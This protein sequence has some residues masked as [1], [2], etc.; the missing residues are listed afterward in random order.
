[1]KKIF[2]ITGAC[3][4]DRH[5]MVEL[6]PRLEK[7]KRMIDAGDYMTL[8]RPRQ[9]G[10]TTT[11]R[12]LAVYLETDYLVISLDFQRIS[13]A[14]F[15]H[16]AAFVH[17]LA[18][19]FGRRVRR[20]QEVPDTVKEELAD[21]ADRT[22]TGVRLA[23]FFDCLSGWCGQTE[24]PI[25]LLIDE[26]DTASDHQVFL[27]FLAQLRAAY[28]DRDEMPAF[29]SVIL[30]GLYDIKNLKLRIRPDSERK[31]NSPWNIAAKLPVD[32]SFSKGQIAAMLEEYESDRQ[33]GMDV[34]S[35]ADEIRQVLYQGI[36]I[37]YSPA[38]ESVNLGRMFGF[39]RDENGWVVIANRMFEMYLLHLFI[40]EES[41]K[42]AIYKCGERDR[43]QFVKNGRLNMR[44]VLEKFVIH[45]TDIY[46]G[47]EE[48][49]LEENGR[50]FFLLYLKP[51]INGTGNYYLEAQTRDARRTDVIVDYS[52]EQFI[53]ELKIWHGNEYHERGENQ[54]IEYLDD[55][56][57]DTGYL[58][59]FNFNK[60]KEIGVKELRVRG[61]RI[62]EAVV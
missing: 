25:V 18:R 55:D 19:E 23:D 45:F 28:L 11:L 56:H 10:K 24:K 20:M 13:Q 21:F 46:G 5:Y 29:Q 61:K 15:V 57:L 3:R 50:R 62:V 40:S 53:V 51:I 44:L 1:M 22:D 31:Y 41:V 14:D 60:K 39:L 30:A 36:K 49:F 27:D 37:P 9:Y 32:L 54:L 35:V 6:K 2:N 8:S 7:I 59:S 34:Q 42:S 33:T 43:N 38:E 4:P 48:K 52:G 58:L 12:M 16:E 17:A 26:V 47:N